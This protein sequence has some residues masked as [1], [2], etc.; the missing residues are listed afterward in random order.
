LTTRV[1][2]CILQEGRLGLTGYQK[3][4]FICQHR[5]SSESGKKSC[6]RSGSAELRNALKKQITSLG[7]NTKIRINVSGCLGHC[8]QGPAMV[9]YPQGTWYGNIQQSDLNN[10]LNQSILG[11]RIIERLKI[12]QDKNEETP[13]R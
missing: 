11:N 4:V 10:I 8:E 7:L 9:I 6:G 5:R 13:S 2:L 1:L 3:H 12:K